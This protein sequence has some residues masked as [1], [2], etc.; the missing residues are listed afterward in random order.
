MRPR[1][2]R[3]QVGEGGG[4]PTSAPATMRL[5][6]KCKGPGSNHSAQRHLWECTACSIFAARVPPGR[7]SN[8]SLE[9]STVMARAS[10][11]LPL[12][13]SAIVQGGA[14]RRGLAPN[15]HDTSSEL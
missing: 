14:G 9:A 11:P 13:P 15:G 2:T 7:E 5:N 12:R 6:P 10:T 3:R 1:V 4:A 8:S